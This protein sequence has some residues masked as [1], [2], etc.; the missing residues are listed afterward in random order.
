MSTAQYGRAMALPVTDAVP[1][2]ADNCQ[3]P[4]AVAGH[5]H[6]QILLAEDVD[7]LHVCM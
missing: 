3:A 4:V 5:R 2:M 6:Q 1:W 7:A